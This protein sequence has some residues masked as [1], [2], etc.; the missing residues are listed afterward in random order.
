MSEPSFLLLQFPYSHFNEKARW[1]FDFK[2]VPHRRKSLLPGP[3]APFVQR[4]TGQTAVPIVREGE[5]LIVGSGAIIDMLEKRYPDPP[6]YPAD[7]AARRRALE[8]QQWFDDDVGPCV[9]RALFSVL[10][11]EPDYVCSMFTE[12]RS[13]L[14]RI[15]YR[16][17]FPLAKGMMK[18]GMGI[19]GPVAVE[20]A[21][22]KTA[23]ALDFVA[24]ESAHTGYLAG[25]AFSVADLA[26][27][28][29]L[30]PAV[31]PPD[32]PMDLPKPRPEALEQWLERWAAHPGAAWVTSVYRRHRPASAEQR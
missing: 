7:A 12:E 11:G 19:T 1:A 4:L 18:K 26:A 32:T 9:R 3:H 24:A 29:L 15:F 22:K 21:Y 16:S 17:T 27:A 8:I 10:L 25:G 14:T 13:G 30:G 2:R 5:D 6:L 20:E 28:A 23:E 31:A